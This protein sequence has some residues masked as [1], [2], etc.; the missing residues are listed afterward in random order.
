MLV[1]EVDDHTLLLAQ[2]TPRKWLEDSQKIEVQRAPTYFGPVSYRIESQAG[3]GKIVAT[4]EFA[5]QNRPQSL[6]IRFRHPGETPIRSVTVDGQNWK[7]FDAGKEWVH[8]G[9]P[10]NNR[11]SV[12]ASY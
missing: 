12:V 4:I 1:R 5:G 7:D 8:I 10:V 11:Y 6:L 3:A 2:A 9:N